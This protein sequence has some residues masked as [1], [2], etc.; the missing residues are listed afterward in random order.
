MHLV[1][2]LRSP[3]LPENHAE[4]WVRFELTD[5]RHEPKGCHIHIFALIK[6]SVVQV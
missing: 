2:R 4:G 1:E 3:L 6:Q 5:V